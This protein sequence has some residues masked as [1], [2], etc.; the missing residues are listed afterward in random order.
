MSTYTQIIYQIVFSTKYRRK[1]MLKQTRP[2]VF[3]YM[4]GILKKKNCKPF[5]INGIEDHVH[6]LTHIHPSISLA[7]L[8]KDIKMSSHSFIDHTGHFPDF[9]NWQNGYGA[10]TY[11]KDALPNLIRYIENQDVHHHGIPFEEE[12]ISMLEE[13]G[14]EYDERYIFD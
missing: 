1:C 7:S 10:F 3:A 14:I 6:I 9:K 8:V 4:A 5:I 13:H 2:K 11:S 12:Y